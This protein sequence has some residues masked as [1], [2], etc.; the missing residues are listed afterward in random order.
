MPRKSLGRGLGALIGST[1]E[2]KENEIMMVKINQ[3]IPGKYQPRTNFDEESLIELA[4]SIKKNGIIQPVVVRKV[5]DSRYEIIAGERRW[6]AARKAGLEEIPVLIKD[7]D[8]SKALLVSLIENIQREDLN[9]VEEATAI[10]KLIDEFGLTQEQVAEHVGKSRSTIA[11]ILRLLSLPPAVK[12][13]IEDG[14]LSSGHAKA[15]LMLDSAEAQ[16][17]LAEI[18]ER[19]ELSV[20]DAEKVARLMAGEKTRSAARKE[21]TLKKLEKELT[22]FI[23]KKTRIKVGK[24][25]ATL[26]IKL[27]E[28]SEIEEISRKVKQFLRK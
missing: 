21:V 14:T 5:S 2:P 1:A 3:V 6:R 28:M 8:D 13:K 7:L 22:E 26:V 17:E 23:G 10:Q 12:E 25:G 24:R 11:N 15:I 27:D 16:I 9:P 18:I 20:R 19:N 4:E